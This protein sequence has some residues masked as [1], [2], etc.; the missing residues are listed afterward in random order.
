M[1]YKLYLL[2]FCVVASKYLLNAERRILLS[3]QVA[4]HFL[5]FG[6]L[7]LGRKLHQ[8][9][10]GNLH[11]GNAT[12]LETKGSRDSAPE[13]LIRNGSLTP[14]LFAPVLFILYEGCQTTM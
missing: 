2:C 8:H 9:V 3:W 5:I 1:Y 10:I 7:G 4:C 14:Q 6:S 12:F 11:P 13:I